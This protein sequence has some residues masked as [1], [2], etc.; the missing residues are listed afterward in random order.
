M[1]DKPED[2]TFLGQEL[3]KALKEANAPGVQSY[4]IEAVL[5]DLISQAE[6]N[7]TLS[8]EIL[9]YIKERDEWK[10]KYEASEWVRK[11]SAL[12]TYDGL[13]EEHK[14]LRAEV[15]ALDQAL[16]EKNE[17]IGRLT[18]KLERAEVELGQAKG[19]RIT[20]LE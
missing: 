3:L 20:S 13:T 8:D 5:K 1:S 12:R 9:I 10:S 7:K 11:D 19:E 6:V 16:I 15:S 4:A 2:K 17:E 18:E 14:N